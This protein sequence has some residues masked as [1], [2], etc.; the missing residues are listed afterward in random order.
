MQRIISEELF[1]IEDGRAVLNAGRCAACGNIAFPAPSGCARCTGVEIERHRLSTSGHLW[2]F[3][4]QAFQ[5][6][7][8]YNGAAE[9][10][11]PFG[12]GYVN[13]GGEVLVEGRLTEADHDRLSVGMTMTAVPV[14]HTTDDDGA[15]VTFA[16]QPGEESA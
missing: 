15:F 6:K 1:E 10:W 13:L 14:T 7:P 3:T 12:V 11:T 5:P 16:F 9:D 2:A 4:V 8:P